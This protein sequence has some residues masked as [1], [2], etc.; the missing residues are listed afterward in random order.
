MWTGPFFISASDG[1]ADLLRQSAK[2][3]QVEV[4]GAVCVFPEDMQLSLCGISSPDVGKQKRVLTNTAE[5]T[6]GTAL[7]FGDRNVCPRASNLKIRTRPYSYTA[8]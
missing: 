2:P 6:G 3:N 7:F 1:D 5:C 4:R 8:C